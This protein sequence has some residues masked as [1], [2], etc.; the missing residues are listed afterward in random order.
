MLLKIIR[1]GVGWVDRTR[2]VTGVVAIA[3]FVWLVIVVPFLSLHG[4]GIRPVFSPEKKGNQDLAQYYMGG[5]ICLE[6]AYEGLYPEP[7]EGIV[8]NVGWPESSAPREEYIA[9]AEERGVE[10]TFRYILPPPTTLLLAPLALLPYTI[11]RWIWVGTLGLCCWGVCWLSY[12]GGVRVGGGRI[13]SLFW[14]LFWAFSP[15]M[16]KTLRTANSTPIVALAIGGAAYAVFRDKRSLAVVACLVAGLLKGTSLVFAPFMLFSRRWHM[17]GLGVVSVIV[18]NVLTIAWAGIDVYHEFLSVVYP[19]TKIPDP[20]LGNQSIYGFLHRVSGGFNPAST[21]AVKGLGLALMVAAIFHLWR[22]RHVWMSDVTMY[23][24]S[25]VILMGL[26]LVFSA[27]CWDHYVLF[28]L[29]FWGVLWGAGRWG[30]RTLALV[31]AGLVWL[32]LAV[33]RGGEL[34]TSE[35]AQSHMLWGQLALIAAAGSLSLTAT[36]L[37]GEKKDG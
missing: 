4:D 31:F 19:S 29:P 10:N 23:I 9:I 14:V 27:Y 8:A 17:I 25:V 34:L 33:V 6:R 20:F 5:A 24:R 28:Y 21:V 7:K 16:L 18:I 13:S 22:T 26:Y 15:L 3:T 35:P 32:P 30:T 36:A 2:W 1:D 12:W 11:A 37:K